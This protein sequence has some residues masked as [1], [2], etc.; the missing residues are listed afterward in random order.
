MG[1]G[2]KTLTTIDDLK[3]DP[4]NPRKISPEALHGLRRSVGEFGDVSSVVWNSR[5]G[6]LVAGHQRLAALRTLYGD[7]LLLDAQAPC[8]ITPTG[9]RFQIRVVDWDPVK[10][11][12]ANVAA[13]SPTIQGEFTEGL[14]E[15]LEEIRE[16]MPEL[17]ED[18]RFEEL[19][20]EFAIIEKPVVEQDEVP[21]P[22]KDPVTKPGDM[23]ILGR[24]RLLCGDS[25]K[26]EDVAQAMGG[27]RAALCLTDP[28]YGVGLDYANMDDLLSNLVTI[29]A[30]FL[31]LARAAADVVLLSPGNSNQSIYPKPDWTMAWFVPA[32][33][34]CGPW[35]FTCWQPILAYGKDP[36]LARGLG[37]RPDALVKTE[38]ADNALGHPCSK[39][40]GVWSW[41]MERGSI[42]RGDLIFDPFSGSG[43]TLV[44]AEQLSR[45]CYGLEIDPGYCDVIVHRWQN[46][47]GEQATLDGDGRTF[48]EIKATR[49]P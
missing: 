7:K 39:P 36:Y 21:D 22:P 23:W 49:Q 12:A 25:T 18:L 37:R 6:H 26:A 48:E 40:V 32:G 16:E 10:Q 20:E 46:L 30:A 27:G 14:V 28:P 13:N 19:G 34:G 17:H 41:F 24:H 5:T 43:T 1:K 15:I 35:G 45:R 8:L 38:T 11:M 9:E 29:V 3:P 33:A 4:R 42:E 2:T 44:A 47:T 31:P